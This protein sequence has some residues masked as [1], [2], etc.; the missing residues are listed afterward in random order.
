MRAFL[1]FLRALSSPSLSPPE[2][3]HWTAPI[4]RKK[5]NKIPAETNKNWMAA[6]ARFGAWTPVKGWKPEGKS[7]RN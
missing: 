1:I 2:E 6:E 7:V 5:K 3:T 4:K